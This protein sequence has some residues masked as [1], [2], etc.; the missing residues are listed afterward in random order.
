MACRSWAVEA[1][2][3]LMLG[4]IMRVT[5]V[6]YEAWFTRFSRIVNSNL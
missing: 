1:V 6:R 5:A 2:S 3:L 4:S